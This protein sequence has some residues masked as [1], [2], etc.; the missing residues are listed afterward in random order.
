MREFWRFSGAFDYALPV[1]AVARISCI[2]IFWREEH[3]PL[4]EAA[5]GLPRSKT[6]KE[7]P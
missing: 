7:Y 4:R 3:I 6:L 5:R 2:I 1:D